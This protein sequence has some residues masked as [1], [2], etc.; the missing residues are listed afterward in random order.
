MMVFY[1]VKIA[2]YKLNKNSCA[3]KTLPKFFWGTAFFLF[4]NTV[5]VGDIIK[6]AMVRN[7]RYRLC[8][9]NKQPG[10]MAQPYLR[11]I[12]YKSIACSLFKK[13]AERYIA[14]VG[15]LGYIR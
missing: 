15:K 2:V 6:A 12:I 5:K 8:S 3:R 9:I 4:K 14:H 1:L 11:L 7:F 13:P 10:C